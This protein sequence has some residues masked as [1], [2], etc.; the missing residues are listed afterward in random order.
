LAAV[1]LGEAFTITKRIGLALIILGVLGIVWGAGGTIG[2]QQNIGHALFIVACM[3]WACYTV[4]MRKARL[5]GLH[6]AA[7]AAVGSLIIYLPPYLMIF[8]TRLFDAPWQDIALQVFVHG[9][10]TALISLIL[11]GRAV[12]ILGAS[13][14]SAFAALCPAI[15]SLAAIP[16]LGE[17][18][19]TI[20]WIAMLLI[21]GGVYFAS[22]GSLPARWIGR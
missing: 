3:M 7:I 14:G 20:D 15:T 16:I 8:E 4:A 19:A 10:L 9:F 6:A 22:G 18:P 21:S 13:N 11:Y 12:S 2:T 5:D 17:W 1:V